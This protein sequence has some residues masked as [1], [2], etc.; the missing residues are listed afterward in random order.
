MKNHYEINNEEALNFMTNEKKFIYDYKKKNDY[1]DFQFI[2]SWEKNYKSWIG[3]NML[4]VKLIKYED[5]YEKTFEVF[6][7]IIEFIYKLSNSRKIFDAK[8][9][10]NSIKSSTFTELKRIEETDGFLES[11][12]SKNETKRIPFFHLG[13]KNDWKKMLDENYKKK[14]NSIFAVDLKELGYN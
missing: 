12:L 1:S 8:K 14:L 4:S 5:L 11:I 10:K 2:S 7:S 13:P 6:K 9:A 3:Q